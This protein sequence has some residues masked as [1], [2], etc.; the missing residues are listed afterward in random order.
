MSKAS[1]Q[2]KEGNQLLENSSNLELDVM[3]YGLVLTVFIATSVMAKERYD[4]TTV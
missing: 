1:I 4:R 2:C 3:L